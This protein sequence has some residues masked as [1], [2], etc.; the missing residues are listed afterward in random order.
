MILPLDL[1]IVTG[2]S[3][4][5]TAEKYIHWLEA[6]GESSQIY[7]LFMDYETF[8]EHHWEDTGI[9]SFLRAFP[10]KWKSS[11]AR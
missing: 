7:N 2:A 5:L 9:F 4:H 10:N 1:V 8:G 3:G 6:N 11:G